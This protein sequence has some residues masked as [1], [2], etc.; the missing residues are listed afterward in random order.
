[1]AGV[2]DQVLLASGRKIPIT[3]RALD[4]TLEHLT[5]P[6]DARRFV[7]P[8]CDTRPVTTPAVADVRRDVRLADRQWVTV[9]LARARLTR[10]GHTAPAHAPRHGYTDVAAIPAVV[11]VDLE[12][13]VIVDQPVAV[14]VHPIAGLDRIGIDRRV[15]IIAV[16][17]RTPV[18]KPVAIHIDAGY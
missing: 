13:D 14:V 16:R 8:L 9:A 4:G 10:V 2:G 5:T 15:S 3:I 7:S 12:V 1:M 11:A 17:Q 18:T 6:L